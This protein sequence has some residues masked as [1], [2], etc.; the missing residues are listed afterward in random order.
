MDR[1]AREAADKELKEIAVWIGI[2]ASEIAREFMP[3]VADGIL[4]TEKKISWSIKVS[5]KLDSNGCIECE[6][7]PSSPS[8]PTPDIDS[9]SFMLKLDR[10]GQLAFLFDGS[11]KEMRLAAA[12]EE[13]ADDGY[14]PGDN[15]GSPE[16]LR[17]VGRE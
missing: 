6:L 12:G 5:A 8:I 4:Q 16:A 17:V 7:K 14:R 3:R 13:P 1:A 2:R 11:A 9:R 15:A 10:N